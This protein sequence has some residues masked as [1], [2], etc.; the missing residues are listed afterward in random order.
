MREL[1]LRFEEEAAAAE[2]AAAA[3]VGVALDALLLALLGVAFPLSDSS[4]LAV[5]MIDAVALGNMR[6][7]AATGNRKAPS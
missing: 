5:A 4:F 6:S 7:K 1:E 2:A 3:A